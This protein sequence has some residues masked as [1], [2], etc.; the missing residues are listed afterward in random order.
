MKIKSIL[1]IFFGIVSLIGVT[2]CSS[3][4]HNMTHVSANAATCTQD[5]NIDHYYCNLCEKYYSD[6]EGKNEIAASSVVTSALGHNSEYIEPV[7]ATPDA[8]G[9][10]GY[11]ECD[12]CFMKFTYKDI[13]LKTGGYFDETAPY[14]NWQGQDVSIV[15]DD[16]KESM[17]LKMMKNDE[18]HHALAYKRIGTKVCGVGDYR[19][20]FDIKRGR[21]YTGGVWFQYGNT[22]NVFDMFAMPNDVIVANLPNDTWVHIE[23]EFTIDVEKSTLD[24]IE[25]IIWGNAENYMSSNCYI[26]VDNI[27]VT[28]AEGNNVDE[29]GK[30]DFEDWREERL[31]NDDEIPTHYSECNHSFLNYYPEVVA[32]TCQG[33]L[34]AYYQCVDCGKTFL[35]SDA[36]EEVDIL[37]LRTEG[38]AHNKLNTVYVEETDTHKAHY[39][40]EHCEQLFSFEDIDI[41]AGGFFDETAPYANW[42]GQKQTITY[43]EETNSMVLLLNKTTSN[44][45]ALTYKRIGVRAT[46]AGTYTFEFDIKRGSAHNGGLWVQYGNTPAPFDLYGADETTFKNEVASD[47]W[48]HISKTF[49]ITADKV[50][51]DGGNIELIIWSNATNYQDENCYIC[52]D[53]LDIQDETG[54]NVDERGN[55]DF[56]IYTKRTIEQLVK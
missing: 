3:H 5:G 38:V 24:S 11:Y 33:G 25:I 30:G 36:T 19:I 37:T 50:A 47:T 39:R 12:R 26:M 54:L 35:D 23:R 42:Q 45:A 16:E 32:T 20:T 9:H 2:G 22:R 40:C 53:N 8:D 48:T 1:C 14:G 15:F 52:V 10:I 43:D 27:Q 4:Q 31:L 55:G 34:P 51:N 21:A 46:K 7:K 49:T 6:E 56:E 41:P 13:P 29:Y 28:D 18:E 17:V 44:H